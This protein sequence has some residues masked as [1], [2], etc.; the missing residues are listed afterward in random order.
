MG[1]ISSRQ[2]LPQ[3]KDPLELGG[4]RLGSSSAKF[5]AKNP[6]NPKLSRPNPGLPKEGL[7]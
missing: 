3:Y 6:I 4:I 2:Q 7:D 5:L 1:E